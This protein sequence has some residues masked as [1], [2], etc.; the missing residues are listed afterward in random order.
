MILRVNF[1]DNDFGTV[2]EEAC[3]SIMHN[4]SGGY[5][6]QEAF[7]RY[8]EDRDKHGIEN[9]RKAI[10]LASYGYLIANNAS[11]IYHKIEYDFSEQESYIKYLD[12]EI[13]ISEIKSFNKEWENSEVCYIDFYNQKVYLQ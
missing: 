12:E 5:N 1:H 10:V 8:I 2:V 3:E 9:I 13:T 6:G 4:I 11:K 7:E